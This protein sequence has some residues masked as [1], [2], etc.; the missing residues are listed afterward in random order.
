M[1]DAFVADFWRLKRSATPPTRRAWDTRSP[2]DAW[3][4]QRGR[5]TPPAS[6]S[7]SRQVDLRSRRSA[8]RARR[9]L[10]LFN[11]SKG[12]IVTAADV[13]RGKPAPDIFVE[14]ARCIGADPRRCRAYEDGES[15]LMS[16]HAAG[17][18]VID[19]TAMCGYP[20]CDGLRR[21]KADQARTRAWLQPKLTSRPWASW[22]RTRRMVRVVRDIAQGLLCG[23]CRRRGSGAVLLVARARKVAR[24]N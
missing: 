9:A 16:A 8:S 13:P 17:C 11:A 23:C 4:A 12:N 20:S 6:Q 15:G 22:P 14:A 2:L 18:H 1:T 3:S 7:L 5:P 24:W 19:V 21:A 10:D